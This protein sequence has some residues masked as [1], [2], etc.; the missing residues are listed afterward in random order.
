MVSLSNHEGARLQN[1][2]FDKL[3]MRV[4][5]PV[6]PGCAKLSDNTAGAHSAAASSSAAPKPAPAVAVGPFA[7]G[8]AWLSIRIWKMK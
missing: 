7:H 2:W 5:G 8:V 1:P 4:L 3:T 6:A